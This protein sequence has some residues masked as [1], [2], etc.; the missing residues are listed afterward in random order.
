MIESLLPRCQA[1]T[2]PNSILD[3]LFF[4]SDSHTSRHN[5]SPQSGKLRGH[6]HMKA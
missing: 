6:L 2:Q 4:N 3:I 1:Q 5:L